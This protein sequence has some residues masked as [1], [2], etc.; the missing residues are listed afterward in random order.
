M[1]AKLLVLLGVLS[2][3]LPAAAQWEPPNAPKDKPND[4]GTPLVYFAHSYYRDHPNVAGLDDRMSVHVQNLE[5]LLAKVDDNCSALVLFLDGMPLKGIQPE[6]CDKVSGHVRYR[7]ER[8][9]KDDAVWHDLLGS[10]TTF[11][12]PVSVS[13]GSTTSFS[14]LSTVT[15]FEL[16]VIP[17][18]PFHVYLVLLVV[19]LIAFIYLCSNTPVIRGGTPDQPLAVRP[20]SLSLFQMAFWFFLVIASYV[21]IWLIC[22]ELNTITDSVLGLIGIGA[23]TAVGAKIVNDRSVG[24]DAP[25]VTHGFVSDVISDSHGVSIH[26]LQMFAWTLVLGVI[27]VASVYNDLSMPEFSS[28]L[29]GLMGI[30]S[31]TYLGVKTQASKT[32]GTT[33]EPPVESTPAT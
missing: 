25:S 27:F 6:S 19:T 15:T 22:D 17:A 18:G 2:V 30:S 3:A 32:N 28:T 14:A 31:G 8:V 7:L 20:Y 4:G 24:S 21:F 23:A 16:E 5:S 9:A 11:K 1:R 13:I 33:P 12:K 29:L 10:P 26:R